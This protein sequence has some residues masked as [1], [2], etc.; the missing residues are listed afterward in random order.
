[1][2]CTQGA[3]RGKELL[4]PEN[5]DTLDAMKVVRGKGIQGNQGASGFLIQLR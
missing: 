2:G 5:H 3:P 4:R 1:M